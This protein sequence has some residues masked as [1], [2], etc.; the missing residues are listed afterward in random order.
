MD[1]IDYQPQN[2]THFR[3]WAMKKVSILIILVFFSLFPLNAIAAKQS[4]NYFEEGTSFYDQEDYKN[5][6]ISFEKAAQADPNFAEAYYNLGIIYDLQHKFS[7]AI[8]A[9]EQVIQ[10]DPNIGTVWENIAQD[11]YAI[12]D[13]KRGMD[14]IKL[15]ESIGKPVNKD[16]YNRMWNEKKYAAKK[17]MMPIPTS[18]SK[19][20]KQLDEDLKL[21]IMSL[22]K[23][24]EQK[25]GESQN[26]I[27]LGIKYRQ[28]GEFDKSIDIF[29]KALNLNIN[30][31][32]IY[33]ELSLCYYFKNQQDLFVQ[34][35]TKAKQ[36]GFTPSRS[37]N[38]LYIQN[39]TKK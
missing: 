5:A 27:N 28:K 29:T 14:Y 20:I 37:L 25:A 35:F 7:K 8:S 39:K 38:D 3:G 11:C 23:E 6:L 34:N 36:I 12:G 4:Y 30:K 32:M 13:L 26:I 22:E 2:Q 9:Y 15:A 17:K 16:L 21:A 33:A 24:L 31:G 18:E 19:P 1:L 10:L